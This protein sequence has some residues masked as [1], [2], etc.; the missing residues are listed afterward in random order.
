MSD[1]T[2]RQRPFAMLLK[3]L[4]MPPSSNALYRF[5]RVKGM[6]RLV[7]TGEL[8]AYKRAMRDYYLANKQLCDDIANQLKQDVNEGFVFRLNRF[9]FFSRDKVLTKQGNVKKRDTTNSIKAFDDALSEALGLDDK[10]FF[11]SVAQ[12]IMLRDGSSHEF[13]NVEIASHTMPHEDEVNH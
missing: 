3:G 10:Y 5:A 6:Q 2:T 11:S 1:E 9:F 4:P 12:K 13:V 7:P 8:K